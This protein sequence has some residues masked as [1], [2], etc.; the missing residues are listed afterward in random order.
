MMT[1]QIVL[2]AVALLLVVVEEIQGLEKNDAG[3]FRHVRKKRAAEMEHQAA[4]TAS[5]V[6]RHARNP[7]HSRD[8]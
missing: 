3:N 7:D 8:T 1:K 5:R 2:L 6:K 4:S